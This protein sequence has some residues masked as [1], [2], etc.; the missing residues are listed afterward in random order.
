MPA[1]DSNQVTALA[2]ALHTVQI[3]EEEPT[4]QRLE[5]HIPVV[6]LFSV[7]TALLRALRTLYVAAAASGSVFGGDASC[8]EWVGFKEG[9]TLGQ[10]Q[11]DEVFGEYV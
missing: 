7:F 1:S 4:L 9:A 3:A 2:Q 10:P 6:P 8:F 5:I 11:R